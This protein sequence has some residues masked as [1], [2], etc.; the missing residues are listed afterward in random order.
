MTPTQLAEIE[1]R[2]QC[3]K[4]RRLGL[5][6]YDSRLREW[7]H[8]TYEAER[9]DAVFIR[10]LAQEPV[11]EAP[12]DETKML[13]VRGVGRVEDEPRAVLVMLNEQPTDDELRNI[14][15]FLRSWPLA[16]EPEKVG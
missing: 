2:A 10:A 4:C 15:E 3:D 13:K 7:V 6:K 9:C 16:Q 1:A 8:H 5:S 14:H 12:R 11:Y